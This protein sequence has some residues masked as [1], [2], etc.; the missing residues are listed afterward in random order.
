MMLSLYYTTLWTLMK[1]ANAVRPS[2]LHRGYVH[3]W[4]FIFGWAILVPVTVLVDRFHYGFAYPIVI[5]YSAVFLSTVISFCELFALP[6]KHDFA[7]RVLLAQEAG[8]QLEPPSAEALIAP[9]PGEMEHTA[10]IREETEDEDEEA[11]PTETTPLRRANDGPAQNSRTT[12]A[13]TYR[14]SATTSLDGQVDGKEDLEPFDHEQVWSA[15]LPSW[16]W[17]L[18]L[19]LLAPIT[20]V[21]FGQTALWL[22]AA[23]AGTGADGGSTLTPY[24]FVAILTVLVL[25]P[26]APF[27]HRVS[28]H[29]PVFLLLIF[30]GT[31]IYNLAAFPFSPEN[32]Y[33]VFFQQTVDLDT[34]ATEVRYSGLEKYVRAIIDELPSA[35][36]RAVACRGLDASRPALTQCA[37]DGA[38]VPPRL[39][40]AGGQVPDGVPPEYG[41]ADLVTV[42]VSRPDEGGGGGGVNRATLSIDARETKACFL[43]FSLPLTGFAVRGGNEW[44]PRFGRF[45]D[46][47]LCQV[48][49]WRRDW[50]R[51]WTVDIEWRDPPAGPGHAGTLEG[52][53]AEGPGRGDDA[54]EELRVRTPA[55]GDAVPGQNARTIGL[56]G[57]ITC[58]WSDANERGTIPALD[59]GWRMAPTWVAISKAT[60]GLVEGR[61]SF[62]V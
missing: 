27:V 26:L 2:A 3:I 18:Q 42:N 7:Q 33:K 44:D 11:E 36:G 59:E 38:A 34:G 19:L 45:P 13:T 21:L 1:G 29:V 51:A 24:L 32:R 9:S 55:G 22:T 43:N 46:E 15:K 62:L 23:L 8:G 56:D 50:E 28:W 47:G 4:L 10:S 53:D 30:A 14:R 39:G 37:Y 31:L 54:R 40:G 41:W 17:F 20:L 6:K 25:M 16:T 61:K 60:E 57:R 35:A 52:I 58:V 48:K 49:L 5:L 12:F